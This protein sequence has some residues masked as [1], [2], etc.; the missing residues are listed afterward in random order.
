MPASEQASTNVQ[1]V[2]ANQVGQVTE[3]IS[4]ISEQTNLL[5]LYA[6]IEAAR[7]GGATQN[8]RIKIEGIQVSTDGTVTEINQIE[9]VIADVNENVPNARRFPATLPRMWRK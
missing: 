8:I 6:S 9:K 2:A 1:M 4:E 7:A 5:A 3:V